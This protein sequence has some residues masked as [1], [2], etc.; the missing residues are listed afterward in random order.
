MHDQTPFFCYLVEAFSKILEGWVFLHQHA[1][2]SLTQIPQQLDVAGTA[3]QPYD[4]KMLPCAAVCCDTA[5]ILPGSS[6]A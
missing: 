1:V 3:R 4:K 2:Q 6:L 5:S